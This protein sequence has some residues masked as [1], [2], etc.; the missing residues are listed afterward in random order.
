MFNKIRKVYK[1]NSKRS[2]QTVREYIIVKSRGKKNKHNSAIQLT[3]TPTATSL[4]KT[5]GKRD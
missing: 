4:P 3:F 1:E 2:F 5:N